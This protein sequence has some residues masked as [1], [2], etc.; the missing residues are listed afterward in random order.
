[1]SERDELDQA[2]DC[3]PFDR[4]DVLARQLC[5]DAGGEWDRKGTRKAHWR[6]QAIAALGC[7]PQA[8]PVQDFVA[9]AWMVAVTLV[10]IAAACWSLL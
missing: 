7:A 5:A 1:M 6:A 8:T 2:C 4:V 3:A 9:V 10:A